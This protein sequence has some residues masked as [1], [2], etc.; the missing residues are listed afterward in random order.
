[1]AGDLRPKSSAR[2]HLAAEQ[3]EC[4]QPRGRLVEGDDPLASAR[5][6]DLADDGVAE[7]GW[8]SL[9][10]PERFPY[11]VGLLHH[12]LPRSE[13]A[14]ENLEQVGF[15]HAIT[16]HQDPGKLTQSDER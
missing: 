3:L 7:V 9:P 13:E 10:R 14:L 11:Q 2:A 6:Q 15:V 8:G 12:D 16:V 1:M 4:R 5:D